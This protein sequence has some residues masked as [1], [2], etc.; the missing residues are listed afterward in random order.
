MSIDR[1]M[2]LLISANRDKAILKVKLKNYEDMDEINA[3][4]LDAIKLI[5]AE[6]E[7]YSYPT[8]ALENISLT[9]IALLDEAKR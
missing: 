6:A 2:N 9:C 3:D 1:L 7:E 8:E 5:K 4:L